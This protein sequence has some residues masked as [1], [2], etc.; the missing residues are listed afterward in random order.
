[1]SHKIVYK[2]DHHNPTPTKGNKW[3]NKVEFASKKKES[4]YSK[5][6]LTDIVMHEVQAVV[7]RLIAKKKQRP[8]IEL[9]DIDMR[10]ETKAESIRKEVQADKNDATKIY[11]SMNKWIEEQRIRSLNTQRELDNVKEMALIN[12]K[13]QNEWIKNLT[14]IEN[15]EKKVKQGK[16]VIDQKIET[17]LE[18]ERKE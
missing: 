1:M 7:P 9:N 10:I 12:N 14:K 17:R 8:N 11:E 13:E 4:V 3:N 6:Q 16:I 5:Q 18:R 15:L 2:N